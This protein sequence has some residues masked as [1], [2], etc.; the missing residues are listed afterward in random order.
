MFTFYSPTHR[1]ATISAVNDEAIHR[2]SFRIYGTLFI[3]SAKRQSSK[4]IEMLSFATRSLSNSSIN[5]F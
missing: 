3:D 2:T 5:L 4:T 1:E